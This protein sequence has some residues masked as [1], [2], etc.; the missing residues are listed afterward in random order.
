MTDINAAI[1]L[2]QL[3][4]LDEFHRRRLALVALYDE[5]LADVP[6]VIRPRPPADGETSWHL[7]VV[8]IDEAAV[9]IGRNDVIE[10]LRKDN[11]GTSVHFIPIHH[12]SFYQERL[13]CKKEQYPN[14]T[15]QYER[16]IS[17]PLFPTMSSDEVV[18]VTRSLARI[19]SENRR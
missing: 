17:L 6:G 11:I 10:A 16:A 7:Y 2:H 4:R 12:H 9:R 5:L 1:G 8:G 3:D 14:A 19:L 15:R 18:P 13:G